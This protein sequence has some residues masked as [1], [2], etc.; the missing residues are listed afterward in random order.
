VRF[1]GELAA[2]GTAVCWAAGANLFAAAADRLGATTLNRLRLAFAFV[3]LVLALLVLRGSPWPT[4]A[5]PFQLAV[6]AASGLIGF[7]FGDGYGFR[8]IVN[9]GPGRATLVMSSAPL[10]TLFLAWPVLGERPGPF[11][12]AGMA[13]LVGG[14]AWVLLERAQETHERVRGSAAAGILFGFLA[15]LGQ[16][17]GY[18]LSKVALRTGIDPLSATVVRVTAAML[19]MWAW[20][21]LRGDLASTLR[22]IRADRGGAGFAA[23][24]AFAG[25]FLGV[26]LSLVALEHIEAG[27]AAAITAFFPILTIL[28]AMR[29]HHERLTARLLLG[30]LVAVAGVIVLFLR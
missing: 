20:A 1:A 30:S 28:I 22:T 3:F 4:W 26:T 9:L 16:A 24:G 23:A 17:G 25:P 19:G 21:A 18:V 14:L 29:F 15:A 8:S 6:L 5:T 2:L 10:F 7:I 11:V 13:L 12:F 27:V